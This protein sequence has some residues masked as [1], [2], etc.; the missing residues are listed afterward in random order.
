MN[1]GTLIVI[2]CHEINVKLMKV[3]LKTLG[4]LIIVAMLA[5][6]VAPPHPRGRPIPPGHSKKMHKP[7][8]H[9]HQRGHHGG[10]HRGRR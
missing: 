1:F 6:C 3:L 10:H 5:S 2:H 4:I 8:H 7:K 9:P